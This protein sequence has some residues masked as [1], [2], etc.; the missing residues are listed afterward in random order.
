ML[1]LQNLKNFIRNGKQAH[2]HYAE[3][4]SSHQKIKLP[5]D[6]PVLTPTSSEPTTAASNVT[7]EATPTHSTRDAEI[8]NSTT[9]PKKKKFD[10]TILAQ[11]V[12]EEKIQNSKL[13]S[14]ENIAD[15]YRLVEK[16][17]DGAF[18]VVYKAFDLRSKEYVA[19]KVVSKQQLD[20]SEVGYLFLF[21][22]F[23]ISF[24]TLVL[25]YCCFLFLALLCSD[26]VN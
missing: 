24:W 9:K 17:G 18:S 7:V 3:A 1:C 4:F 22:L 5:T 14:Y 15:N 16:I 26:G 6:S 8:T 11:M 21:F 13:P 10:E 19:I 23:F 25:R 20:A 2:E 12:E